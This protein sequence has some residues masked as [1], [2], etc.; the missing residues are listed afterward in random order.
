MHQ[1]KVQ[2]KKNFDDPTQNL[3][4]TA[5]AAAVAVGVGV[6]VELVVAV[7]VAATNHALGGHH[8]CARVHHRL[9]LQTKK[10]FN[11]RKRMVANRT[12]LVHP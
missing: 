10:D 9:L 12:R 4:E 1:V 8:N 7:A 11:K 2:Q 3:I 5:E 6:G